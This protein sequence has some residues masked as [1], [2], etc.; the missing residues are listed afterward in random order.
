MLEYA[1]R[2]SIIFE[3]LRA[4]GIRYHESPATLYVWA[5][6]PGSE[7]SVDFAKSLLEETGIL[8]APGIGFG[9]QGEGYFRVSVTCPTEK[10]EIA[11][12]RLNKVSKAAR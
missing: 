6:V 2:R 4:C 5:E 3:G 9:E 12:K 10:V 8:V 1:R 11:G 7:G